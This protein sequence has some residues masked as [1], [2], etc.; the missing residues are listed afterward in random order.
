MSTSSALPS[1]P[2]GHAGTGE[3]G[4]GQIAT[5]WPGAN[6]RVEDPVFR[7]SKLRPDRAPPPEILSDAGQGGADRAAAVEDDDALAGDVEAQEPE[8]A[9]L[10]DGAD[11]RREPGGDPFRPQGF[12]RGSTPRS[13]A[14]NSSMRGRRPSGSGSATRRRSRSESDRT[15]PRAT[16]PKTTRLSRRSS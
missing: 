11:D 6:V 1:L 9:Q 2:L 3:L 5:T 10:L 15:V 12:E 14:S 16:D 4:P 13:T 7:P 8:T